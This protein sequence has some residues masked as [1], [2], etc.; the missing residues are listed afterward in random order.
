MRHDDHPADRYVRRLPLVT[1]DHV[2]DLSD[3]GA[4]RE[5]F[6]EIIATTD[7]EPDVHTRRRPSRRAVVL[8][9]TLGILS[10][11]A[12]GAAAVLG[13]LETTTTIGCHEPD[14]GVVVLDSATG[15][16]VEDC[17]AQWQ[18]TT[19]QAAP[20]LVAYDNGLG[21]I[22]VVPD[23][24]EVPDGWRPL[25]ADFV[26]HPQV[27]ELEAALADHIAG[28]SADCYDTDTARIVAGDALDRVGL[29]GWEIA[30]ERGVADGDTTC[31]RHLIDADSDTVTL[32]PFE[33]R[34]TD[35][36]APFQRLADQLGDFIDGD[37]HS[38][39]DIVGETHRLAEDLDIVP[40][41][42]VVHEVL[43]EK[44]TCARAYVRVGGRIEATIYSSDT[45]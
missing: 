31:A 3:D 23:G 44:A 29:G 32:I 43:D 40:E 28:L 27:I 41:G 15:D 39:V 13:S 18:R 1:D 5:L 42:L 14:G 22:R 6:H 25:D 20:P 34:P 37:C 24:A 9:A 45:G 21:G 16:P 30:S 12:V 8:A 19:G 38:A 36:D 10:L 7:Q 2:S 4:R 26:Q 17:A 35:P 11:A 33:G